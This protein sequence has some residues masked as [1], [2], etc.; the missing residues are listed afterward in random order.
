MIEY[1]VWSQL[2]HKIRFQEKLGVCLGN[3]RL[4][5]EKRMFSMRNKKEINFGAKQLIR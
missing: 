2:T 4:D 1:G 5:N 3:Q